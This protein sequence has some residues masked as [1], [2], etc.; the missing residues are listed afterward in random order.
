ML[1]QSQRFALVTTATFAL[2]ALGSGI[3]ALAADI[4]VISILSPKDGDT[5]YSGKE[6]VM[7]YEITLG[8]GDDHFHVWVDG[9]KSP[10]QR[11]LKGSY[12][13][14]KMTQG[15]H[16]IEIKIVDKEHVPTGPEQAITVTAE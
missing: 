6:N 10:P 7:E 15:D 2:I 4:G 13:L 8:T 5:L 1:Y 3:P 11:N 12:T 16:T 14:P 9:A